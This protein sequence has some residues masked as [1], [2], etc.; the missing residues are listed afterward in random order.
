MGQSTNSTRPRPPHTGIP[1][2]LPF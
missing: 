2:A 1:H